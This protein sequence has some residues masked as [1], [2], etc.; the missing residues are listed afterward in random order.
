MTAT[1]KARYTLALETDV[2]GRANRTA[3]YVR[4]ADNNSVFT[5]HVNLKDAT[6]RRKLAKR[7][8]EK[9]GDDAGK[10][11]KLIEK[12]WNETVDE[13]QRHLEQAA[14]GS[15]EA[16]P[17]TLLI[18]AGSP[19]A[20]PPTL[21]IEAGYRIDGGR[22]CRERCTPDGGIAL[23]PLCNFTARIVETITRDDGAEQSSCFGLMG[24]LP[25]G[26]TLPLVSVPTGEFSSLSWVTTSWHGRAIVYAGQG[27]RDQLRAA[28]E[29]QSTVRT[30]RT[31]YAHTGWREIDGR[32]YYLHAG[33]ALGTVGTGGTVEG[34]VEVD[35]QDSL[36]GYRLPAPPT[37]AALAKAI[38]ASLRVLE[39][40][41]DRITVPL[42]GAV[43][44]SV[45]GSCDCALHLAGPTGTGK[46]EAAALAQQHFGAGLDARHLPG[47]WSSTGNALEGL[48]FAAKDAL[49]VVDDFA[50]SG[51]T[52]DVARIHRE[53]DRLLRAQGNSAGRQRMRA[54]ATIRPTRSP[55]G[56]ILSTGEDV[57]RGQSL[58]ARL[59]TLEMGP[60]ELDW[61]LLTDCQHDAASGRYAEALAA[62]ICW[63]AP[64]YATVR[65][66]LRAEVSEL[67]EMM[68]TDNTHART[69]GILADLAAGW[70]HWLDFALAAEAIS[71][72]ERE[73][74]DRR[75][76]SALLAS[77]ADQ[78]EHLAAAEPCEH[79]IRLLAAALASG[80]AH[81]AGPDGSAPGGAESEAWGWRREGGS[82]QPMG[83]RIG[84]IDGTALYLE[85]DAAH[86]EAQELARQQGDTLPLSPRTL[87][88]RLQERGF[89]VERDVA[90]KRYTV[91]RY[92]SCVRRQ[93]LFL[94]PDA[95][96]MCAGPSQPSPS[97][98]DDANSRG[99]GD[100]HGD[101]HGDT[102]PPLPP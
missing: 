81:C 41:P 46:S 95:L 67:R 91:R 21:L 45:L 96:S 89:L 42:L 74:L 44:R 55:R 62:Y 65:A 5:D 3:V 51:S 73:A 60:G 86:A 26:T 36:A 66:H 92:L 98:P 77:G 38:S 61:S 6:E 25:D 20:R 9:T 100:T 83:R 13:K 76:W 48:A 22:L 70:C 71:Q 72:T 63:L 102:Q 27:I 94:R 40:A 64:N 19:E 28:I 99:I 90:R 68:Q 80:R 37:G 23:V 4:D 17:P 84:W 7:I 43:Y 8:A 1:A 93:V 69:P 33:G 14:A 15:P 54:D 29:L 53:A 59:L 31:V 49:F 58:R 85:P 101:T 57:P 10:W 97:A 32:W 75:V 88:R 78:A 39:L 34:S 24:T 87:W 35:L 18:E 11:A 2:N 16:R 52:A 56:M 12:K 47:A 79:F 50:P 82:W 30:H